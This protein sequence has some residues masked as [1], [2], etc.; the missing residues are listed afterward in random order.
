MEI[1]KKGQKSKVKKDGT[2][3]SNKKSSSYRNMCECGERDSE[4]QPLFY[5]YCKSCITKLRQKYETYFK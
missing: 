1:S 2:I 5:G 3:N 4:H